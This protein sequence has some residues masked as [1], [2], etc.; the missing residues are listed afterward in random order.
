MACATSPIPEISISLAPPEP[1]AAEPYSPFSWAS[2]SDDDSFRP[3]H[4]TP[5]PVSSP[6]SRQLSPLRPADAPVTGKGLERERFEALLK[7]SRERNSSV[8]AKKATDLRKEIALKTHKSKQVERRALFLS[9]VHAPP[10]PTATSTP[11]TPPESP[12]I[13]HYTLPSPGL[14]SPLALFESLEDPSSGA[15]VG[16][17]EPWVEQVDFRMP[18]GMQ[19]KTSSAVPRITIVNPPSSL[20][21]KPKK[22]LPSL[23]QITARLSL[24][25][26][27]ASAP[28]PAQ[29][30]SRRLPAFLNP[31]MRA[32]SSSAVETPAQS[33]PRATLPIGVGRLKMPIRAAPVISSPQPLKATRMTP[34]CSPRSPL[35]PKLQITT[36]VVPR[37]SS[38]SPVELS[39]NNIRVL[40]ESRVRTRRDM[41]SKLKRR[42]MVESEHSATGRERDQDDEERRN[43]R[44]SAPAELEHHQRSGFRHPVL[45]MPGGF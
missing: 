5:P 12:A 43:R 31:E 4:L 41:F 35:T 37:T 18:K 16:I 39:E 17:R 24:S 30:T 15:R 45:S 14:V 20:D 11:K 33:K 29:S 26:R 1:A 2:M 21:A 34:P 28:A 13:F 25:G 23:D 27:Q 38:T 44:V 8:G 42:T 19:S 7:A 32:K 22:S 40:D 3:Q 6:R 36:L 10:S 9:K